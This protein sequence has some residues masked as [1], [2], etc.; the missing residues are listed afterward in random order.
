[1]RAKDIRNCD[2]NSTAGL[3]LTS[4]PHVVGLPLVVVTLGDSGLRYLHWSFS[5]PKH[6][7]NFRPWKPSHTSLLNVNAVQMNARMLQTS[8]KMKWKTRQPS[9]DCE[10]KQ[11]L[12]C[13]AGR[14]SGFRGWCLVPAVWFQGSLLEAAVIVK[15]RHSHGNG[16]F[17]RFLNFSL[18]NRL[19]SWI[20]LLFWWIRFP[21]DPI[22]RNSVLQ[23]SSYKQI[24]HGHQYSGV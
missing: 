17:Y 1:M 10:F 6:R 8:L 13:T 23:P 5:V 9:N 16:F 14:G 11:S 24:G 2:L 7:H 21:H 12:S 4:V 18:K 22:G 19:S 20:S 15:E 3:G